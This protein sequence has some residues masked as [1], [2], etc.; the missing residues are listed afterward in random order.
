M[1][2]YG[3]GFVLETNVN[4]ENK[5]IFAHNF[6]GESARFAYSYRLVRFYVSV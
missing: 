5:A 4:G 1:Y 3:T 2:A 6:L